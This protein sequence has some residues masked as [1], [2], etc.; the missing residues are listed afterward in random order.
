MQ[1]AFPQSEVLWI[2]VC[3]SAAA[4]H[5]FRGTQS[6]RLYKLNYALNGGQLAVAKQKAAKKRA[7]WPKVG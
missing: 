1:E 5:T 7:G 4:L 6:R 2:S 3:P